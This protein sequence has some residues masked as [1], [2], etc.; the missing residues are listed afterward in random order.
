MKG[1]ILRIFHR[2]KR[3]NSLDRTSSTAQ[4]PH[5]PPPAPLRRWLQHPLPLMQRQPPG[6]RPPQRQAPQ[7]GQS[8]EEGFERVDIVGFDLQLLQL[9]MSGG[10][11]V[12][13]W[14]GQCSATSSQ[15]K[16]VW[17]AVQRDIIRA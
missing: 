13:G 15:G 1:L 7:F 8:G 4:N 2:K 12:S 5:A 6:V 16:K 3:G 9:S 17:C 11:V 10:V 14:C